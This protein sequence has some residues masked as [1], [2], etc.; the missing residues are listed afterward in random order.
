VNASV[1]RARALLITLR[2]CENAALDFLGSTMRRRG[3]I[4][5]SS[6]GL[7]T[8]VSNKFRTRRMRKFVELFL[9]IKNALMQKNIEKRIF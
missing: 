3:D 1:H 4:K 6:R 2:F 5:N 9:E 7:D 8:R